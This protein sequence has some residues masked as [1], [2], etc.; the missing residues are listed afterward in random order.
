MAAL[1]SLFLASVLVDASLLASHISLE[2]EFLQSLGP[3]DVFHYFDTNSTTLVPEFELVWVS[4]FRAGSDGRNYSF[5]AQGKNYK[6]RLRKEPSLSCPSNL[7]IALNTTLSVIKKTDNKCCEQLDVLK[8]EDARSFLSVCDGKIQGL[9]VLQS[10][11]LR[12]HPLLHKHSAHLQN[13]VLT[14]SGVPH[15]LLPRTSP[16]KTSLRQSRSHRRLQRSFLGAEV[17]HLEL[18]V[19]VGP[20]VH[21]VHKQDTEKYILTNLNIASEL[22]RDFTL[23]ANM[24]VHLIR[25]I[26]LTEPEPGIQISDDITSSL[27]SVCEWGR[28]V[29]PSTETEPLHADLLLYI[30]RFDLVLPSGNKQ[31]R[32]V[33]QLGGVCSSLWNCVITEDTGFDL[34]IT[35]AHEI[36][37]SLGINHDGAD[38]TCSSSGFIMASDGGYN[39]VD[40]TWSQCSRNQF[41]NFYSAGKAECVNDIPVLGGSLQEWKPGLYYGVDDQCRIAFGST[42]TACSFTSND[43]AT[44]RF[45][46]CHIIPGDRSTCTRLLVPLLDGTECGLNQWC[47]KGRCVSASK[48]SSS[49]LVHGSWSS[50]SEYSIC[51]RTCGGGITYRKRECNNPRPAFGGRDCE[52]ERT[53]AELCHRQPCESNQHEFM[54]Q[55]CSDTDHQP[56]LLS[57]YSTTDYSWM[58]AVGFISGDAQCKLMC[59]SREQDFMVSRGAQFIDGTRCELDGPV[60]PGSVTACHNG[61][62]KVFGC[63]GVLHSGKVEDVCGVCGGK[64]NT[65][66][67]ITGSFTGGEAKEYITFLILPVNASLVHINNWNPVFTHMAVL[68]NDKYVVAGD[69]DIALNTTHPS[70]LE[71]NHMIYNLYL[72]PDLLPHT[73]ELILSGPISDKIHVQVYRKYGREYGDITSPNITYRYYMPDAEPASKIIEARWSTVISS[74]SV[75]C[76]S[77]IQRVSREC[78]DMNTQ[79]RLEDQICGSVTPKPTTLQTCH[80]PDC[81]P[82]WVLGEVSP[83]SAPCGIGERLRS[84]TCMQKQGMETVALPDSA[85][86]QM[87]KPAATE[88][89]NT[90]MCSARWQISEPGECSA[91]CGPGEARRSVTCIRSHRGSD[92]EVDESLCLHPKPNEHVSCV[93][94]VCP[95]GWETHGKDQQDHN[96]SISVIFRSKVIPVYVWS[97]VIGH[98]TKTC[99]NGTQQIWFSC[100]DHQSRL[101]VPE[102]F[103]DRFSKPEP[104]TKLCIQSPCPAMYEWRYMQGV[105]SVS[106]GG[107]VARRVLYCSQQA[108]EG[109]GG[110][111]AVVV[112]D[113]ACLPASKPP[114][115]VPCNTEPC[116]ARWLVGEQGPCSVSCGLGVALRKVACVQFDGKLERAVDHCEEGKM[117]PLTVPCFTQTCSFHWGV[118]EWSECSVSC[119][120]GIQSRTVSC[121]G[122]SSPLPITPI[123]CVHLPKPITIQACYS[124]NCFTPCPGT[125]PTQDPEDWNKTSTLKILPEEKKFTYAPTGDTEKLSEVLPTVPVLRTTTTLST[126]PLQSSL[127]GQL[128]LQDTGII[129]LQNVSERRCFI[130]IGR[131]LDEVIQIKI[132]SSSLNCRHKENLALYERKSLRQICE[133]MAGK[134]LTSRSNV[135][136]VRQSRLTP[137]N[138]VLLSYRSKKNMKNSHHEDCDVQLF[139]PTGLI[140]NPVRSSSSSSSSTLESCRVFINAPPSLKIQIRALSVLNTTS[141]DS[142]YVLIRDVDAVKTT[143]FK[144][145][146]LFLWS[147]T[148]SRAEVEFYGEYQQMKG[149]FRAEYS[150]IKPEE[151]KLI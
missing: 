31:V 128:F 148:G 92:L 33:T 24:R 124:A 134:T 80:Q 86:S 19:V 43:M 76:G 99:G 108:T 54:A 14:P 3:E 112:A 109:D 17:T 32:G 89:C 8:P 34:G 28:K 111:E 130:S 107:G 106:C 21:E 83:C 119:G 46:S 117:P 123:L 36:G 44:C 69:G 39:S 53:E 91:V 66:H 101:D 115:V 45:L 12:I 137:G 150:Y 18:L 15:L 64:G 102:F 94:D 22:L 35:I 51:S 55:Q 113:S 9:L 88:T 1:V 141:S 38:N 121:L 79:E 10:G 81:P 5:Q 126:Q 20:D 145:T 85:C 63:D 74:C 65:C 2:K 57:A 70:P 47:L 140:E 96:R 149:T 75:T 139:S 41:L 16:V 97:P 120:Y 118:Q 62:C 72:S 93:V 67:L 87:T 78:V 132:E 143:V 29:N 142:A 122:P 138:G 59:R 90:Q 61:E 4:C 40:L 129:D 151:A 37:H 42:A 84:V 110:V 48:L 116:P 77:G 104:Y 26:V 11:K 27:K 133:K 60:T 52:G 147:S 114:K 25:M 95:I 127:C 103:C 100:V 30:T 82:S 136:L 68:V 23:G 105:C 56:L 71:E 6:L 49:L 131:P 7:E 135:L 125:A 98:C 58:P 73:E 50:W 146:H 13:S 144:G